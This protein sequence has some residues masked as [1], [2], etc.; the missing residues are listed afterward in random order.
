M[1][2]KA[3]DTEMDYR[4][5]DALN[6]LQRLRDFGE[7][8][9]K[10]LTIG[11]GIV[12]VVLLVTN[13]LRSRKQR[14]MR[15]ASEQLGM[16]Q[17]PQ[18]L[19]AIVMDYDDTPVAALALLRLARLQYDAGSYDAALNRYE[20]FLSN[21]PEHRFVKGAELGR[22]HC[23]EA[24]GQTLDAL[25]AYQ[26]FVRSNPDH[27]LT[28]QAWFGQGRCLETLGRYNEARVLYEDFIAAYPDSGWLPRAEERLMEV[29]DALDASSAETA[30]G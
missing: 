23:M 22:V 24:R 10:V 27:Y 25:E 9:G 14:E 4:D 11:L 13:G 17:S 5:K 19:E 16:A 29:Q 28:P 15:M 18:A 8:H 6:D 21:Y 7:K 26:A 3:P 2:K 30:A 1:D 20:E 12:A